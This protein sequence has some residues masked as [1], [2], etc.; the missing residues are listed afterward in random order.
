M[1]K[2]ITNL[3]LTLKKDG[4]SLKYI[5]IDALTLDIDVPQMGMVKGDAKSVSIAAAFLSLQRLQETIGFIDYDTK[6]SW[7][8]F[9]IK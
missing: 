4:K 1:K 3:K 8:Q 6:V 2:A 5:L 9:R 7:I